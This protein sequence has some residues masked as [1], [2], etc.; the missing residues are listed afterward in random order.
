MKLVAEFCKLV[1]LTLTAKF[2]KVRF[3]IRN[4]CLGTVWEER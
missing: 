4:L 3:K 2:T 1:N